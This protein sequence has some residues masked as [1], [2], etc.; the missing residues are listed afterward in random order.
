V[1]QE[2]AVLIEGR[3]AGHL[4]RLRGGTHRLRYEPGYI[5]TSG[6]TPLSV[7][8]PV[9][10]SEHSERVVGP[11]IAGLL[12]D[13][14]LVI[15][16]WSREF[17][18]A[19]TPFALLGTRVGEDCAGA[20]QIVPTDRVERILGRAG[21]TTWLSEAE[22][23]ER[24]RALR[25]DATAWLGRESTGRFSLAGAQAKTAL[26]RDG[27]RW[28]EPAGATPTSHILKPAVSGL[29]E[30]DLNEHLCLSAAR[31]AGLLA[32]RSSVERFEDQSAVV[33]ER[34]DR[35][36]DRAGELVR[37]HQEDLCQALSIAPGAKYESEGGPG[38]RQVIDLLGT[39][40]APSVARDA[41][42]RFLDALIWNWLIGGTDAHAKNYSLL[43]SG[44][45]VRLAPLYDVA[46]ALPYDHIHEHRMRLAMR[47][48]RSYKVWLSHNP[49]PRAAAM[50]GRRPEELR[51]RVIDL[52]TGAGDAFSQASAQP[53]VVA[54]GSELP[55]R[56]TDLVADRAMRC[57]A[58]LGA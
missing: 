58:L 57:L 46:S 16:R 2:L 52:A 20:V 12:P 33:V 28:G 47:I 34:Y 10:T 18:V 5:R 6:A 19:P 43:L 11:W 32:A 7:S 48:G 35:R 36:P 50:W 21:T 1:S 38:A 39:V 4:V 44:D 9:R 13:N 26:L 30:H 17:H 54:L 8:M 56:L 51:A 3:L 53:P 49:W 42:D 45:Q 22:V 25:E 55:A 23:A 24:L 14:E 41:I 40:M 27:D 15:D 31:A 29:D 37:V